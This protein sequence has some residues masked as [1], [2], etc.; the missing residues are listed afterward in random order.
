MIRAFASVPD[1]KEVLVNFVKPSFGYSDIINQ[2]LIHFNK[3]TLERTK[4]QNFNYQQLI[5]LTERILVKFYQPFLNSNFL[6]TDF[7][8]DSTIQQIKAIAK[9]EIFVISNQISDN[10]YLF[11]SENQKLNLTTFLIDNEGKFKEYEE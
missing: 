7:T 10:G 5:N 3:G 1:N 11:Y 9:N 8:T 4:F 2:Q 6:T